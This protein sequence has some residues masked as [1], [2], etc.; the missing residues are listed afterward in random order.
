MMQPTRKFF[1]LKVL[2]VKLSSRDMAQVMTPM[3]VFRLL[4]LTF[5]MYPLPVEFINYMS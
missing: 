4:K 5:S 2:E 3:A 1:S